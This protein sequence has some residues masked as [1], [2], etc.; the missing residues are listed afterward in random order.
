[1]TGRAGMLASAAAVAVVGG[2]VFALLQSSDGSS[3]GEVS[4]PV[5]TVARF[6]DGD[7]RVRGCRER[8]EGGKIVPNRTVDA[9]IGPVAFTRLPSSYRDQA[10]RPDSELK[11]YPPVGMPFMKSIGVLRSG[12]R[13]KLVVPRRQRPW[14]KVIYDYPDHEGRYAITLRACR[15]LRSRRAQRRECGWRPDLACRWR[16]T[17]FSGGFGVDFA[18]APRRGVCA[19]LIVRV[20]GE[21]R[22]LREFLFDPEPGVCGADGRG[23]AGLGTHLAGAPTAITNACA[24]AASRAAFPVLCPARWPPPRG[25]AAPKARLFGR[26]SGVYL[27]NAENGIGRR[28]GHVFHLLVGGQRRAFGRWPAGVDPDL[29]ITTRK[30]TIPT[31]DGGTF[32]QQLPA[33]RIATARVHGVRAAVLREPPYPQG[34]IHGGHVVVPLE[35]GGPRPSRLRARRAPLPARARL[36]RP[37]DGAVDPPESHGRGHVLECSEQVKRAS[38]THSTTD[39]CAVHGRGR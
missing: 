9:V 16:Y 20:S 1:M 23:Y 24:Q 37:R 5:T 17:Q 35:R 21:M 33:R 39:R 28:G 13:V 30:V 2:A 11:P 26:A 22:P 12:A 14:M 4:S 19:E 3:P 25:R 38:P 15:R 36:D 29:R 32:V 10:A 18:N 31:G 6:S 27:I 34:G 7:A 8:V